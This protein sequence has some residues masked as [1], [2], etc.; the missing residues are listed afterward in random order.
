MA[1]GYMHGAGESIPGNETNTPTLSTKVIYFPLQQAK[2]SLN[3]DPM[4]RDDELRNQDE[5]LPVLTDAYDPSWD[6]TAR[7]YPDLLGFHLKNLLGPPTTTVGNG[8][9]TDPDAVAIPTGAYKH[10]WTAPFGPSGVSPQTSQFQLAYKD[11]SVF[12][13]VKGCATEALSLETPEKGGAIVKAS[14][15][16]LYLARIADPALSPAYESLAVRPFVRGNLTLP[17]WL[18]SSATHENFSLAVS[19]PVTAVRSLGIASKYPDVMEKDDGVITFTGSLSQRQLGTADWDALR[20]AT[21]FAAT[22]RWASDSIIASAY[23]YKLYCVM[24]AAQYVGGDVDDL[25]NKRRHGA[26]FNFKATNNGS[27][28]VVVTLVNATSS[29]T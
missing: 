2:A 21:A 6:F 26:Q 17:T 8:V 24:S 7:A 22:A 18:G 1:T 15:P 25:D 12:Y 27:T 29:Y 4:E 13:K 14:G 19:N 20:D 28:S 5:P 3:P 16:A 10:V 9:I 23:P 11:Q